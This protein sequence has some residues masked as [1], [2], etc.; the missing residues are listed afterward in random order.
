MS[1]ALSS[2]PQHPL[3]AAPQAC[4]TPCS[5]TS[6]SPATGPLPLSLPLPRCRVPAVSLCWWQAGYPGTD[7]RNKA[8]PTAAISPK[9][10]LGK[11]VALANRR[12]F[13]PPE[14]TGFHPGALSARVSAGPGGADSSLQTCTAI[15]VP[16][17]QCDWHECPRRTRPRPCSGSPAQSQSGPT[18]GFTPVCSQHAP[19]EGRWA[20]SSFSPRVSG[21]RPPCGQ[22]TG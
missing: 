19:R 14:Q 5:C 10:L 16:R 17:T 15:G 12:A 3:R 8:Q 9:R 13:S 22:G 1:L 6:R 11:E 7:C 4:P 21:P 18:Q 2:C 20:C